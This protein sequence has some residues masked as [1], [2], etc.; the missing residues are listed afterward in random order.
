MGF[1]V[2]LNK[3]DKKNKWW[4]V[5]KPLKRQDSCNHLYYSYKKFRS[6]GFK[7]EKVEDILVLA[8]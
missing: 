4:L 6:L 1:K 5:Q 8:H 3:L 2:D 7:G